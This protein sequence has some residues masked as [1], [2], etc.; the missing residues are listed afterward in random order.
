MAVERIVA[1]AIRRECRSYNRKKPEVIVIANEADPRV[2]AE[3]DAACRAAEEAGTYVRGHMQNGSPTQERSR[4]QG[5]GGR[6]SQVRHTLLAAALLLRC[7]LTAMA[8]SVSDK[9]LE[10]EVSWKICATNCPATNCPMS[11]LE[12]LESSKYENALCVQVQRRKAGRGPGPVI[13]LPAEI[14][15]KRRAENPREQPSSD[16]DTEYS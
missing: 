4:R 3:V 1:D 8:R 2:A 9:H 10:L 7:S 12:K 15:E 5:R 6:T 13:P 14:I 11:L 16:V